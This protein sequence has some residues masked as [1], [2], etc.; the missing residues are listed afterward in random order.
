[1]ITRVRNP[2]A[3][4]LSSDTRWANPE[5]SIKIIDGNK[6]CW[7]AKGRARMFFE[8][9]AK[10]IKTY[11]D[12]CIDFISG[13]NWV[14]WS[15]YM[16]GRTPQTATP[17]IMFFCEERG[18]RRMV[19][20]CV[21][22]SGIL[23]RYPGVKSGNAPL[24]PDLEQLEPLASDGYERT[25]ATGGIVQCNGDAYVF[26]AGHLFYETSTSD[27]PRESKV[28]DDKLE[29]DSDSDSNSDAEIDIYDNEFVESTS[30]ASN[31]HSIEE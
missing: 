14:T 15:I 18:P 3:N 2:L 12:H 8:L 21:K 27:P 10:D 4:L 9:L 29:I 6:S 26:T 31:N 13:S 23:K 28:R 20:E 24:P 16:I 25:A 22:K 30:Q 19:Q 17:V 1:M 7:K 11:S 5:E